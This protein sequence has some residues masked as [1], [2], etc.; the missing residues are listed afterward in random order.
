VSLVGNGAWNVRSCSHAC[1]IP[2]EPRA[3]CAAA[4]QWPRS[5]H[6][7]RRPSCGP[8]HR[9]E[10]AALAWGAP[11]QL[12]PAALSVEA[13]ASAPSSV[14]SDSRSSSTLIAARP[15]LVIIS[16]WRRPYSLR[17]HT[18][19]PGFALISRRNSLSTSVAASFWG[20]GYH[21]SRSRRLVPRRRRQRHRRRR[22]DG[23]AEEAAARQ[24]DH[25]GST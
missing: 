12:K 1:A 9:R 19:M 11:L 13:E 21:R 4:S 6:R 23:D 5:T 7:C 10:L 15:S 17:L 2:S 20:Q 22:V 24:P 3:W 18:G 8:D 16:A 14:F 25:S